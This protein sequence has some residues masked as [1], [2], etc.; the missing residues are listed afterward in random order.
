[1]NRY[2]IHESIR[3]RRGF[4]IALC[5]GEF[6]EA[7]RTE[8]LAAGDGGF[9]DAVGVEQQAVAGTEWRA[10]VRVGRLAE[11]A[12]DETVLSELQSLA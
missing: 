7:H 2:R 3:K 4:R 6:P 11:R 10:G 1:M 9:D 8:G 5:G 12:Q